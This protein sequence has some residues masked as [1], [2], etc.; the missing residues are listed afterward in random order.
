MLTKRNVEGIV[1]EH[2]VQGSTKFIFDT[3]CDHKRVHELDTIPLKVV[4]RYNASLKNS[5]IRIAHLVCCQVS[6]RGSKLSRLYV[7]PCVVVSKRYIECSHDAKISA[8]LLWYEGAATIH[9]LVRVYFVNVKLL[10]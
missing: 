8:D 4:V 9:Q 2:V 1:V 7:V 6:K 5:I 3:N 10:H